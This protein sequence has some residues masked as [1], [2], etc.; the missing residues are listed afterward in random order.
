MSQLTVCS[1]VAG[2]I[3]KVLEDLLYCKTYW[4]HNC[5]FDA[6]S[7]YATIIQ[8][9]FGRIENMHDASKITFQYNRIFRQCI[10][11]YMTRHRTYVIYPSRFSAS[12]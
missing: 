3:E 10:K 2:F 9:H 5:I 8:C 12:F 1:L 11:M 7:K 6:S 4:S